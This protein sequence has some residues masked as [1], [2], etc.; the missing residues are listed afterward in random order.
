MTFYCW[1]E[2]RKILKV[3]NSFMVAIPPSHLEALGL[4]KG[5]YVQLEVKDG[6]IKVKPWGKQ[7]YRERVY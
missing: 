1:P 6:K 3:G 7:K 5:H 2:V 4:E